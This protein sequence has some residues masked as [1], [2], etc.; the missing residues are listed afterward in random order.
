MI[1]AVNTRAW[2]PFTQSSFTTLKL[3][4]HVIAH[5]LTLSSCSALKEN[6]EKG[7]ISSQRVR[8]TKIVGLIWPVAPEFARLSLVNWFPISLRAP[9]E[10]DHIRGSLA[11]DTLSRILLVERNQIPLTGEGEWAFSEGSSCFML[12]QEPNSNSWLFFHS[13]ITH[14]HFVIA[15]PLE[16]KGALASSSLHTSS[17]AHA[18]CRAGF[19]WQF[20]DSYL[21]GQG[22]PTASSAGLVAKLPPGTVSEGIFQGI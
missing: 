2:L 3:E 15:V 19:G 9:W 10:L 8:H 20:G 16:Y 11:H 1:A 13:R 7:K 14:L 18:F 17:A 12:R 22:R 21:K 6:K 4:C 5:A